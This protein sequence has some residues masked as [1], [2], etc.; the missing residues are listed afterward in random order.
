[1]V[2]S[3]A[4]WEDIGLTA[5]IMIMVKQDDTFIEPPYMKN[6]EKKMLSSMWLKDQ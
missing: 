2:P 1:L 3:F 6:V 5:M 4:R